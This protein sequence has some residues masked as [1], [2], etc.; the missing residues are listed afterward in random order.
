MEFHS[1]H[2]ETCDE[3]VYKKCPREVLHPGKLPE[4]V[5]GFP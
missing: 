2:T 3:M 4:Q 1:I 5:V